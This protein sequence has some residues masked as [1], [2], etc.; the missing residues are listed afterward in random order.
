MERFPQIWYNCTIRDNW[1]S[2]KQSQYFIFQVYIR[3]MFYCYRGYRY[4]TAEHF[5]KLNTRKMQILKKYSDC[6]QSL[7]QEPTGIPKPGFQSRPRPIPDFGRDFHRKIWVVDAIIVIIMQWIF[8]ESMA[9]F[10]RTQKSACNP[11]CF[12]F[13]FLSSR[14]RPKS[15]NGQIPALAKIGS[16]RPQS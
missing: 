9:H 4:Y 15:Q 2:G 14:P 12:F 11:L 10:W 16:F 8:T 3:S 5:E 1:Y 7:C 6:I 13:S